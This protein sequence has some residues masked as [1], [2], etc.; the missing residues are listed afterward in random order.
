MKIRL[1]LWLTLGF[2][3]LSGPS[4][5]ISLPDKLKPASKTWKAAEARALCVWAFEDSRV[6]DP[7]KALL[8]SL[9]KPSPVELSF[10][11]GST[12]G[13][14]PAKGKSLEYFRLVTE[15]ADLGA[16]W[17]GDA[18]SFEKAMELYQ[19]VPKSRKSLNKL[20]TQR[21]FS[22]FRKSNMTNAYAPFRGELQ[23]ALD[24]SAGKPYESDVKALLYDCCRRTDDYLNGAIPNHLYQQLEA[25]NGR[26]R[27][28]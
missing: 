9:A 18:A 21:I 22:T 25:N 13:M 3:V 6:T 10:E 27:R 5:A 26:R 2:L 7:E 17:D 4:L 23:R 1:A 16:L 8:T 11:N 19:I 28:R 14:D 24:H 15:K 12:Q 20:V